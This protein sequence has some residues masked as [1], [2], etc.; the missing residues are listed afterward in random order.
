MTNGHRSTPSRSDT[1]PFFPFKQARGA[2]TVS[3]AP[4]PHDT[5][6]AQGR[7]TSFQPHFWERGIQ[8]CVDIQIDVQKAVESADV[9][10]REM[11]LAAFLRN[12]A[13]KR[14]DL[15]AK[16]KLKDVPRSWKADVPVRISSGVEVGVILFLNRSRDAQ[17]N[18]AHRLG[19]VLESASI[20]IVS[21]RPRVTFPVLSKPPDAFV[22]LNLPADTLHAVRFKEGGVDRPPADAI[23]VWVNN[24]YEQRLASSLARSDGRAIAASIAA[25]IY[26]SI[27]RGVF[28]ASGI[29]LPASDPDILL[30][31]IYAAFKRASPHTDDNEL[32]LWAKDPGNP[33]VD[34][35]SQVL[36]NLHKNI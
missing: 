3:I 23:E 25:S 28:G 33:F 30:A 22:G 6:V 34:A 13:A 19:S 36:V 35:V 11:A 17:T 21:E 9:P 10:E 8:P 2:L 20:R 5:P 27:A 26:A 7:A 24:K 15:L 1:L 16:W 4:T 31:K 12:P 18:T 29:K 14:Y 32:L